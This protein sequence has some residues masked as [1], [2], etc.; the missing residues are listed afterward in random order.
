MKK[1]GI[2]AN[3][4]FNVFYFE[5]VQTVAFSISVQSGGIARIKNSILMRSLPPSPGQYYTLS[6]SFECLYYL[7]LA[8]DQ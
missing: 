4:D 7:A 1:F 5:S 8:F 6:I 2:V 3:T